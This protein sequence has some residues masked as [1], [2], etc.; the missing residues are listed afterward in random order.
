MDYI[1]KKDK[2]DKDEKDKIIQCIDNYLEI[3]DYESAFIYFL[4]LMGKLNFTDRDDIIHY[5][6]ARIREKFFSK[7]I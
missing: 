1:D 6:N 4:L 2:G 5:Y 7:K 3:N